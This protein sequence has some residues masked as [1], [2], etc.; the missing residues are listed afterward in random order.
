MVGAGLEV[1]EALEVLAAAPAVRLVGVLARHQE[2]RQALPTIVMGEVAA[3]A[4]GVHRTMPWAATHSSEAQEVAA[5]A[6]SRQA[7]Q[8]ILATTAVSRWHPLRFRR[9]EQAVLM[10]T[11]E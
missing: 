7:A 8:T 10:V 3:E 11:M 4:M 1:L 6:G 5:E 9:A 2:I